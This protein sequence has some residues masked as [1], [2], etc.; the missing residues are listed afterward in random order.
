VS[1][2]IPFFEHQRYLATLVAAFEDQSYPDLEVVVVNDGS[3]PEP[4]EAFDRVAAGTRDGRFRS[5]TTENRGPG[6][7]RNAAAEAATGDLLLFFDADDLPK[8]RDFV[9][10]LVRALR[11]SGVDCLT[12]PCDIVSTDRVLPT[13]Q[14]VVSTYRPWGACLE[15][16]FFENVL[17]D[18][19]MILQ[20]SVFTGLGGFPTGRLC[21][22]THEF[23]LRL[24]FRGFRLET[25][26]EAL[27]WARCSP[28]EETR[29][30]N[31]FPSYQSLFAQLKSAPSRDLARIIASVGGPMLAARFGVDRAQRR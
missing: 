30:T 3:G 24:C 16:G 31:A 18:S 12:C 27:L 20:R 7:A 13:E 5:L 9:A 22:E 25:F 15:A 10:S 6:A 17:G 26:P 8:G 29:R 21:W 14:D 2:C 28:L 23:L 19:T 4:S 1:V 11:W